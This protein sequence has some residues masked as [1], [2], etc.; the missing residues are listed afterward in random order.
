[1]TTSMTDHAG[2]RRPVSRRHRGPTLATATLAGTMAAAAAIGL[3]ATS[4]WLIATAATRPPVLTLMVA[5]VTVRACGI[6]RGVLRYVERLTGHDVV[7]RRLVE[8]RAT[9]VASLARLAP[10]GAP[11]LRAGDLV[12]RLVRDVDSIVDRILRMRL[13]YTVAVTVG[14]LAT[15]GVM[16]IDGPTGVGLG[17]TLAIAALGAPAV[18]ALSSA[19]AESAIAP[20]RGAYAAT[21]AQTLHGAADL[22]AFDA[23]DTALDRLGAADAV[24]TTARRSAAR[25]QGLAAAVAATAAGA[26]SW[27]ALRSGAPA[28]TDHSMSVAL[29]AVLVLAPMAIHDVV[30]PLAPAATE[31]PH[32]RAAA[33]RIADVARRPEPVPEPA[34]A[35]A[36]PTTYDLVLDRVTVGWPDVA[37]ASEPCRPV[38]RDLSFTV[39][40]GGR[41]GIVG[42]SGAGKSTLAAALQR[43]LA[44]SSGTIRI[45]G[46]DIATLAGDDVRRLVGV[47]AQDAYVFDSTIAENVRLARPTATDDEV[48]A[49][50]AR[51]GLG[52]WLDTL[53]EGIH[54]PVGEHGARLSGG[55]RQRLALARVLLGDRPI[56]V[57]D[58]PTEHLD[59]VS[60]DRL[61]SDLLARAGGRTVVWMTHRGHGLS[62][63]DDIVTL[64]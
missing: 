12:S 23:A 7:L 9:F 55:Q 36:L 19:R 60:A 24:V 8:A 3:T 20:A 25:G 49:A 26:A 56:V 11:E 18:A 37:R 32:W 5:I 50:L 51:S 13:P 27:W 59:E 46:I 10:A 6:A 63:V 1:M 31:I 17:L 35:V 29:L 33:A 28:A 16:T 44:P 30:A 21:V 42:R 39:P 52:D 14:T 15:A 22:I 62:L 41:L 61:A 34:N 58:E 57:F 40:A 64:G 2:G 38:L 43:F 45:G 54:T 53:T 48:T 47:C 4:A